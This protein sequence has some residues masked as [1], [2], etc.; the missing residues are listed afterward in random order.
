MAEIHR[1]IVAEEAEEVYNYLWGNEELIDERDDEE[2]Q[3]YLWEHSSLYGY[4]YNR[5]YYEREESGAEEEK[6]EEKPV[7]EKENVRYDWLED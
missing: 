1:Q 6:K 7:E 2:L 3:E 4:Y 5:D